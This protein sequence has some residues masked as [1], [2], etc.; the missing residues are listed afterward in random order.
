[1]HVGLKSHVKKIF[2]VFLIAR[3]KNA[4]LLCMG[5][6]KCTFLTLF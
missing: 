5:L 2:G 4:Q 6:G 3:D 1:M